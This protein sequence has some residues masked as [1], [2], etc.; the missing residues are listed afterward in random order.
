M[1]AQKEGEEVGGGGAV[2]VR[3][4]LILA[5]LEK[6]IP[7]DWASWSLDRR[8]VFWSGSV[9]GDVELVPRQRVCALE[10]WCELFDGLGK[11]M[12]RADAQE[13]N[14]VIATAPGW[15]KSAGSI[16]FGY[17]GKQKGWERTPE[18]SPGTF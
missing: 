7:R 10:I 11:D 9:A 4:G 13:I 8:R 18:L 5:F 1:V 6:A 16:R 17:C 15:E 12:R 14:S 2:S 3:A